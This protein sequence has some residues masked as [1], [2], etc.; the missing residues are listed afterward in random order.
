MKRNI[1]VTA[2]ACLILLS[3]TGFAQQ[4]QT[5]FF[6]HKVPQSNLINPA[7]QHGC[8]YYFSGLALPIAGQFLPPIHFNYNNNG[9]AFNDL[10]YKGSGNLA[11]S[12]ITP[13]HPGENT[14]D[15]LD[16]LRKVNYISLEMDINWLSAGY[17][18]KKFYFT[19]N[20]TDKI[21]T[22]TSFPGDLVTLGWEGNGKSFLG[23]EI[24]L[25]YMGA[26]INWHREWAL[27]ASYDLN[28]KWTVGAKTKLLFGKVNAWTKKSDLTWLTDEDDYD[29]TFNV[30]WDVYACQPLY[31]LNEFSID[32][33]NDSLIYDV[34]TL[35]QIDDSLIGDDEMMRLIKD[36]AWSGKNP[37]FSIDLGFKYIYNNEITFYGSLLDLGFI[38]YKDN[39]HRMRLDGEFYF[40]GMDIQPVFTEDDSLIEEDL[41]QYTDSLIRIFEPEHQDAYYT[42]Y[43]TPRLY[44]GGTYTLNDKVTF[45]VLTRGEVFQ[46][47]LHGGITVSVISNLTKWFGGSLSYTVMNNSFKAVGA[48]VYFKVPWVQFYFVT[49]NVNAFIWPEATRN[50]NFRMGVNLLFGCDKKQ[51]STLIN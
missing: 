32:Y 9:F 47:R 24:F 3:T 49:D 40:D 21:S 36:L 33:A 20:L 39:V 11:D 2:I 27:G 17:K 14:G 18:W 42:Y 25:S 4:N 15:F 10:F 13:F 19:F 30:D 37:G 23:K 7:I 31:D 28:S 12:L 8:Q 35:Y 26:S 44:L 45:G 16:Q 43:L 50:V 41:D 38:R 34:D 51:S 6:M 5:L 48:G 29:Y 1:S 22:R 46:S